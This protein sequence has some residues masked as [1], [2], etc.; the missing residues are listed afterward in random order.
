MPESMER[1]DE[2]AAAE[3]EAHAEAAPRAMRWTRGHT[4]WALIIAS[5][6][7]GVIIAVFRNHWQDLPRIAQMATY[8]IC[9]IL[10][11]VAVGLIIAPREEDD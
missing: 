9:A 5:L 7:P 3:L 11:M 10:I 2:N 6:I 8:T 4:V 1:A